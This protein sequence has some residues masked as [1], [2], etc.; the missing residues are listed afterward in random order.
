MARTS[1][2]AR[3]AA[4]SAADTATDPAPATPET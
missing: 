3:G 4:R 1:T 2:P